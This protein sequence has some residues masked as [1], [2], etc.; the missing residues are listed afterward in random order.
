MSLALKSSGVCTHITDET[1]S[2]VGVHAQQHLIMD[3]GDISHAEISKDEKV[4][5]KSGIVSR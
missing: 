5:A 3:K 2:S 4:W 1:I